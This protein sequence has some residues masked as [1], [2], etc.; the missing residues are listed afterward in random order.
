MSRTYKHIES[1]KKRKHSR[2]RWETEYD[3]VEY[4]AI[5]YSWPDYNETTKTVTRCTYLKKPNVLL[6]KRKEVDTE[7]HWMGTPSWWTNLYM[8]RPQRRK[9]RAWEHEVVRCGIEA[10]EEAD[11]PGVGKKPHIYYYW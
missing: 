7:D 5:V 4:Q 8:L 10:L 11:P 2:A 6:K 9:G 1:V 3:K